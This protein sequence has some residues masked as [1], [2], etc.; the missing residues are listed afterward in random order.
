MPL[1]HAFDD[2]CGGSEVSFFTSLEPPRVPFDLSRTDD[3]SDAAGKDDNVA[4]A[5][6]PI[7]YNRERRGAEP[8]EGG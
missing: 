7:A 5:L 8:P 3:E 2:G 1:G 6:F 4:C